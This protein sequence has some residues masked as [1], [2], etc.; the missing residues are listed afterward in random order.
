[1][2]NYNRQMELTLG[3]IWQ[4]SINIQHRTEIRRQMGQTPSNI[5]RK[6][7]NIGIQET[8]FFNLSFFFFGADKLRM[9]KQHSR[10]GHFFFFYKC[11]QMES[12]KNYLNRG[13]NKRVLHN[14]IMVIP[15][16]GCNVC[17]PQMW[18]LVPI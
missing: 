2:E 4:K 6:L 14:N 16:C 18:S 17:T 5:K 11:V 7:V 3:D 10:N 12:M 13:V 8:I 9:W 15:N 1:M